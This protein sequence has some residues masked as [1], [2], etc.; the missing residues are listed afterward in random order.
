MMRVVMTAAM[1]F[2]LDAQRHVYPKLR[3][4]RRRRCER[5]DKRL[6][7]QLT[8]YGT[9]VAHVSRDDTLWHRRTGQTCCDEQRRKRRRQCRGLPVAD[10]RNAKGYWLCDRHINA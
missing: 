9:A 5:R 8:R 6:T 10:Q 1:I 7:L 2:P 3:E 4:I